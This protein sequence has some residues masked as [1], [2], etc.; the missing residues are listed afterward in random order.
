MSDKQDRVVF[1]ATWDVYRIRT[2]AGPVLGT[3]YGGLP[4]G[5]DYRWQAEE[6]IEL[7][8]ERAEHRREVRAR[9]PLGGGR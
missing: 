5:Y 4:L 2:G 8:A 1:D 6:T 7:R 9:A 3:E